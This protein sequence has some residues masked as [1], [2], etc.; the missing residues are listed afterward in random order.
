MAGCSF[1]EGEAGSERRVA[2]DWRPDRGEWLSAT[3]YDPSGNCHNPHA[4]PPRTE[5]ALAWKTTF[6]QTNPIPWFSLADGRL[7]LRTESTLTAYDTGGGE[8]LWREPQATIGTVQYN[9]GRLYN[10]AD[11]EAQAMTLDGEELWRIDASRFV[12][13]EMEGH[14][15]AGTEVG[16]A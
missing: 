10:G 1:G 9:D 16:L 15:Y 13:G 2:A 11:G 12:I 3:R 8:E 14:V 5:P 7:F 4:E 6:E